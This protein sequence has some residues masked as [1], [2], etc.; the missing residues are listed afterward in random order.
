[1]RVRTLL[2]SSVPLALTA[3]AVVVAVR[4]TPM[5]TSAITVRPEPMTIALEIKQ[6]ARLETATV[7]AQKVVRATR[8][9]GA[10]WGAL[11]E[12]MVLV[13][14]GDVVAG[15]DLAD[16]EAEHLRLDGNG[17]LWIHVP[18][19]TVWRVDLDEQATWVANRDRGWLADAHPDLETQARRTAERELRSDALRMGIL[20]EARAGAERAL[21]EFLNDAGVGAVHVV[22][23][24]APST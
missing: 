24:E 17:E 19:P 15:V 6:L 18:E 8:G 21:T 13:A 11:E 3:A 1:M 14:T 5:A 16:I 20:E 7:T 10:L 23:G 4:L 9:E 22:V 12:S 2:A